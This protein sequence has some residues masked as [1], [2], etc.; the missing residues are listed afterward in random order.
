MPKG[1]IRKFASRMGG[2]MPDLSQVV[3][4]GAGAN[5]NIAI[6]GIKTSDQIVSVLRFLDPG[7]TTTAAVVDH[8][9]QASITS[10]GNLQVTV[11]TNT[12]ANDRLVV[13]YWSV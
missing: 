5:T 7:V 2:R 8:T 12:N 11:A 10:D 4:A 3:V 6:A 13:T 9:A 1:N